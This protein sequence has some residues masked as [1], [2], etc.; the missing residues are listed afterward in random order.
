MADE[1]RD[2]VTIADVLFPPPA[3]PAGETFQ[4]M[5][6]WRRSSDLTKIRHKIQNDLFQC[7]FFVASMVNGVAFMYLGTEYS[8][9]C[10]SLKLY[11]MGEITD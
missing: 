8:L 1:C 10:F 9:Y 5:W 2:G 6:M 4:V 11:N 7:K 3:W